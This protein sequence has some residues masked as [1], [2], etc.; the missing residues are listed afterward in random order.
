MPSRGG[1]RTARTVCLK[2]KS[3]EK[4]KRRAWT[5]EETEILRE[6]YLE[7]GGPRIVREMTGR[8]SSVVSFW[9]CRL[10]LYRR[11][12]QVKSSEHR[13]RHQERPQPLPLAELQTGKCPGNGNGPCGKILRLEHVHAA[14]GYCVVEV[15][16]LVYEAGHRFPLPEK[17]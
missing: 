10:G 17:I 15:F 3:E 7:P 14:E 11:R 4:M 1:S 5:S 16:D 12:S 6:H 2:F 13:D 9:A 8:Q